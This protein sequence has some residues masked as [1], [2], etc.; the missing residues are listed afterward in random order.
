MFTACTGFALGLAAR[1]GKKLLPTLLFGVVG[2]IGAVMLHALWN[3]ASFIIGG[4]LGGFIVYYIVLQVPIFALFIW[5]VVYLRR[6]EARLTRDRLGDY[7]AA[8]WFTPQEIDMLAT[9]GGRRSGRAWARTLP[10][11]RS[12]IKSIFSTFVALRDVSSVG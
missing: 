1:Q 9:P 11:D 7:A 5:G 4:G 10:G 8:G 3:G 6:E 2:Y 12:G